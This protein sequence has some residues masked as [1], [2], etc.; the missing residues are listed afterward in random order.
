M[1][2]EVDREEIQGGFSRGLLSYLE[3]LGPERVTSEYEAEFNACL[4]A[5]FERCVVE[6]VV[7]DGGL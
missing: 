5:M 1:A 3:R 7:D 6:P 2:D 4:A